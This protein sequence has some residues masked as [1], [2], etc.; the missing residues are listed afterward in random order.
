VKLLPV[1]GNLGISTLA[2]GLLL[3]APVPGRGQEPP[4]AVKDAYFRAVAQHFQVPLD[5]VVVVGDWDLDPDE[6]PVVLF[7]AQSAGISTD[8]L[9]GLRRGGQLWRE[10]AQRFGLGIGTLHVP[11][12]EGEPLGPLARAYQEFRGRPP[13]EWNGI[14]LED[15]EIICLVNIRV[16]SEQ[17]GV[18]P[19]RVLRSREEAGS[20]T[21]GFASLGGRG[22]PR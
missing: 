16:L 11:L 4:A 2:A 18:P 9:I 12:P 3:L 7:F 21:A 22:A 1:K 13:R 10:V 14:L 20:F 19:L 5:E 8:A 15:S 6:V 17:V